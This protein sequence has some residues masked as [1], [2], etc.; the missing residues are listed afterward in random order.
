MADTSLTCPFRAL[1]S[2]LAD[3][4]PRSGFQTAKDVTLTS[5]Q[6]AIIVEH[7][8]DTLADALV[9]ALPAIAQQ[10]RVAD[11]HP[12]AYDGIA[13]LV[14]N[15]LKASAERVM[16]RELVPYCDDRR[17]A[18]GDDRAYQAG[19]PLSSP[20]AAYADAVGVSLHGGL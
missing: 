18:D 12:I 9:D 5:E 1:L 19:R 11:R 8:P 20:A 17:A 13:A 10:L 16:L 2:D 14:V 6:V 15:A 4:E 3:F 7:E